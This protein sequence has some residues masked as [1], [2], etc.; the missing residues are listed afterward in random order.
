MVTQRNR[1]KPIR[2]CAPLCLSQDSGW[3][4]VSRGWARIA[5]A[6]IMII[7]V[8]AVKIKKN[9]SHCPMFVRLSG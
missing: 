9:C 6:K 4:R 1:R 5:A 7:S 2:E 8:G 3:G